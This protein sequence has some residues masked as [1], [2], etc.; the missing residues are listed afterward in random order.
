MGRNAWLQGPTYPLPQTRMTRLYL[1]SDGSAN[2]SNGDGRLTWTAPA[3]VTPPDRYVYDPGDPTPN[4]RFLDSGEEEESGDDEKVQSVD[5]LRARHRT[6]HGEVDSLRADI[7]VYELPA[8]EQPL[9][10]AGPISAVLYASSSARD[11]D[12]FVRLSE[13][14]ETGE[15][16]FLV[17]GKVRA[18]YR[19]STRTPELLQPDAIYRYDLDL[20]QT[21]IEVP[22]GRTLR[23]E[24]ASASFPLFSRNLNTG[25]HNET[26]KRH[27]KARQTVYHDA[28]HPSHVL[29]PVISR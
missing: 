3:G 27:I 1:T 22:A 16:F 18:R 25:A 15:V 10:I 24:I 11:T 26:S 12:W 2:T 13:V 21:G 4:P 19:N 28:A 29:L 23:V 14:D 5:A 8:L 20:W 6:Y 9:T 17:E 7:L